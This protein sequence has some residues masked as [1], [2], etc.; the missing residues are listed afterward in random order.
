MFSKRVVKVNARSLRTCDAGRQF[1]V[2][3]R[4]MKRL[5]GAVALTTILAI[6]GCQSSTD[7]SSS[8]D[9]KTSTGSGTAKSSAP[10]TKTIE[11]SE[12]VAITGC[13]ADA[14]TGYLAAAVTVTN[15][16]SKTSNYI[17]T[18]AF[19][20]KDGKTQL[21]TGLVAVNNLDSGQ[22]TNQTA[23]GLKAAP[24]GG[25]TCKLADLTRFA[26]G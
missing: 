22:S 26:A 1:R 17:V 4:D 12:D 3:M 2:K 13:A 21:D 19:E 5:G 7:K 18:I 15:K 10:K 8:D 14:T 9:T 25:Y 11:H 24:A 16:S 23:G 6:A 20:S